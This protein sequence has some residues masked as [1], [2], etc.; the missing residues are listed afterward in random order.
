MSLVPEQEILSPS[1][2][3]TPGA[4]PHAARAALEREPAGRRASGLW[5][6]QA[7]LA[8]YLFVFPFVALF[9]VFMLYPLAKSAKMSFEK[10][11][12]ASL[13]RYVGLH[14]YSFLIRDPLFWLACVN[15]LE[16]TVLFL[17]IQLPLSLGLA[18][19]LNSPRLRFRNFFR[20]AF[21][22]TYFVG[23][24]FLATLAYLLLAPRQGMVNRFIG[25]LL[26]KVGTEINWRG[27]PALAMP[28][29]VLASLWVTIG[30]AMIYW[31][32]ALQAV[33]RELYEAA[34]VD[35]AGPL[36]RFRHVTLPGVRPVG[37]FLLLIGTIGAL[38]LFELPYDFFQGPGPGF[39]G[40]TIVGYLWENGFQT[41][42]IGF[43]AAVGW[44]LF[45]MILL[46]G[47]VQL[48]VTG[49]ARDV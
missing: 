33:D 14:N 16:Y 29:V 20:F 43:A 1:L 31:L 36:A 10:S 32:A 19:L 11:S 37:I 45:F 12:G 39:R 24:V 15:T 35:G 17:A 27:E 13:H 23:P 2:K 44:V 3:Q 41:G 40:M 34:Q 49:A 46:L 38:Q 5:A 26:P 25:F 47:L 42:D 9:C 18:L 21:F 8:P 22:S 28:A 30:Y 4:F 48:K 6:W 7:R